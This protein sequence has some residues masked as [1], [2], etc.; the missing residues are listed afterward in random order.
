MAAEVT[1]ESRW[2]VRIGVMAV[3]HIPPEQLL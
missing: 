3:M 2:L 1:T